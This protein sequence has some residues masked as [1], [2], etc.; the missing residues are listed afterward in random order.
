MVAVLVLAAFWAGYRVAPTTAPVTDNAASETAAAEPEQV[1]TCAMHPSIRQDGP[2]LCPICNMELVPVDMGGG[3]ALADTEL[4]LSP[5]AVKLAEVETAPVE[6]RFVTVDVPLAGKVT[7]DETRLAYITAWVPG[8]LD[9]LYVDYTG[10]KVTK[11]DHLVYLYSQDLYVM[12]AEYLISMQSG[13]AGATAGRDRLL[14]AGLTEEQVRA[15]ERTR[16]PKLYHTIYSPLSGTV[17]ERNGT[18]GMYVDVGTRIYTVADLSRVWVMLEAYEE[19]LVWLRYGQAVRFEVEAYPGTIFTGQVAFISP[20]LNESTRTVDV[21]VIADNEDGRLKPGFLVSAHVEA[22]VAGEG[23]VIE[24]SLIDKWISPMHPEIIKDGPGTCDVCGIDLVPVESLGYVDVDKN[25]EPPLVIPA[26]APL[27]TGRRAVVY[28]AD[29]EREGVFEGREVTLGPRAGDYYIVREGLREGEEVVVNG[30][31]KIDSALQI[32]AKP[33]MM[34]VDPEADAD[35]AE[36]VDF[37]NL[38]C[39]V[40][41]GPVDGES[42]VVY[43]G[44]RYGLCCAGCDRALLAEPDKYLANLPNDGAVVTLDN[45]VCPVMGGAATPDVSTIYNGTQVYFCCSGCIETFRNDP[46]KYFEILRSEQNTT[47]GDK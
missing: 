40:M 18:E 35:T 12:Q 28:V 24:P 21:R 3:E 2:G 36:I 31:F 16:E 13:E 25:A 45:K 33:S 41:G 39:P 47:Q 15:L 14:L 5:N 22:T 44:V 8:R 6:R 30:A 17:V 1:Y 32:Q 37:G 42:F 26:S 4:K 9:R 34:S 20:V 29:P 23:R 46:D 19:D 38:F 7:Y 27:I 43:N 11:G 10:V